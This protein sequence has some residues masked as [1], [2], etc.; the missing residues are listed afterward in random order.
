MA[1]INS[2][3]KCLGQTSY[4]KYFVQKNGNYILLDSCE[5][6]RV[7]NYGKRVVIGLLRIVFKCI[8]LIFL[9]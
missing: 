2:R 6:S 8:I 4:S 3:K 1:L 5:D 9:I 7:C